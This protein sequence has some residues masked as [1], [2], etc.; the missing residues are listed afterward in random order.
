MNKEIITIA[1]VI[2]KKL[3]IATIISQNGNKLC[4]KEILIM[5]LYSSSIIFH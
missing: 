2:L 5:V 1:E 3:E 4:Y